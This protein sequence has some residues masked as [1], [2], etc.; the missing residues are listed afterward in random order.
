[1]T[2]RHGGNPSASE[3]EPA[4]VTFTTDANGR[5]N[6]WN[7]AAG[8]LFGYSAQQILGLSATVLFPDETTLQ[9]AKAGAAHPLHE[10]AHADD[11]WCLRRDGT[12]FFGRH[13]VVALSDASAVVGYV[14]LVRALDT[15]GDDLR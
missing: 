2:Q 8:Q 4:P 11:R 6:L 10:L 13:A 7:D 12:R 14:R 5:V 1:M 9:E 3:H 15:P